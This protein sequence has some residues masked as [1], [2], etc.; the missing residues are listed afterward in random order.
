MTDTL[1]PDRTALLVMDC[2]V[3]LVS[4][5]PD[6]A[7]F[8]DTITAAI[9][10][11]RAAGGHIGWVRIGFEDTEFDAVPSSSIMARLATPERR[12]QMHADA[13]ATQ[14]HDALDRQ[15]GDI[16]V[17]KIRVGAFTTT[18]L[19]EQ[20]RARD[21]TTLVL[22]GISTSGVVL[23]TVREAADRDYRILVL[24]DAT[25]DPDPQT[26]A[27]LTGTLFPGPPRS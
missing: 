11:T 3:G 24:D 22:A 6:S 2:Q 1:D 27:F 17:R 4:R 8:L 5:V 20:L 16:S 7:A 14:I 26:H 13:P 10:T 21:I 15:P 12:E 19:H 18:D 9:G 23:S 25:F